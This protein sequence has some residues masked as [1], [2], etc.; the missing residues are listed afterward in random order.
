MDPWPWFLPHLGALFFSPQMGFHS[1]L[2]R[3]WI[4]L[5]KFDQGWTRNLPIVLGLVCLGRRLGFAKVW[6]RSSIRCR[7]Y[8]CPRQVCT[9][10]SSTGGDF[11]CWGIFWYRPCIGNCWAPKGHC[12]RWAIFRT[13]IAIWIVCPRASCRCPED[14]CWCWSFPLCYWLHRKTAIVHPENSH[15]SYSQHHF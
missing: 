10:S 6:R 12:C 3:I 5:L 7:A 11:W 4:R 9:S 8:W 1:L 15:G 14:F 13:R 2:G